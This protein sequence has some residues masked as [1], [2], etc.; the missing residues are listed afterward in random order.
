MRYSNLLELLTDFDGFLIDQFGV[1]IDGSGP[2]PTAVAALELLKQ[3]RK[4]AV[5]ITN[6][7]KRADYNVQSLI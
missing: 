4:K 1:L 3:D 6:S 7:E 2:Y 5:I